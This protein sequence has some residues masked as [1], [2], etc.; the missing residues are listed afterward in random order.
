VST[1]DK[2]G[3]ESAQQLNTTGLV[4]SMPGDLR[5][6]GLDQSIAVGI[7][8]LEQKNLYCVARVSSR[9]TKYRIIPIKRPG[10]LEN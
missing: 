10:R 3:F 2:P 1:D 5:S 8:Q 4:L 7:G 6:P 9:F